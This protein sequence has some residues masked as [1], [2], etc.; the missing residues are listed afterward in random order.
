MANWDYVP[1]WTDFTYSPNID[2]E[3]DAMNN[4]ELVS[5]ADIR[6]A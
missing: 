3:I 5:L 4:M 6:A 2:P 1:A